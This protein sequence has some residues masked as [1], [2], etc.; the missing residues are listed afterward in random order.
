M[1]T[2]TRR[3]GGRRCPGLPHWQ[4]QYLQA[5]ARNAANNDIDMPDVHASLSLRKPARR[6]RVDRA[7]RALHHDQH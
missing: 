4:S 6:M 3:S 7:Y 2:R 5:A 1:L